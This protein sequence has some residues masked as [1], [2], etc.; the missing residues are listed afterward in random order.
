[1]GG[2]DHTLPPR[3]PPPDND[4][5]GWY[6]LDPNQ[7]KSYCCAPLCW[8]GVSA[9]IT[10]MT[11]GAIWYR[12]LQSGDIFNLSLLFF[13]LFRFFLFIWIFAMHHSE[14][15][16]EGRCVCACVCVC[17]FL[18]TLN[19]RPLARDGVF[20]LLPGCLLKSCKFP[21]GLCVASFTVWFHRELTAL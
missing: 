9:P 16:F 15:A 1:M 12:F 8:G 17:V 20:V 21:S 19:T 11:N 6:R 18:L 5:L 7:S 10:M 4:T 2:G 3:L 13:F 14:F